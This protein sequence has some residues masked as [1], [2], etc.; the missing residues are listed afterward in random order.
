MHAIC[1][2]ADQ[3]R[4]WEVSG[5]LKVNGC[6]YIDTLNNVHT[7]KGVVRK[8]KH[9]LLSSKLVMTS[10][11]EDTSYIMSLKPKD[12]M[13]KMKAAYGF[14]ILYKVAWRA[15]Q[16]A[17]DMIYGSDAESLFNKLSWFKDCILETNP[18][19]R[20]VLEVDES[21]GRFKRLFLAYGW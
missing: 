18:A 15:R 21:S 13:I 11:Q 16:R 12:I 9:K 19:L 5:F 7:C 10:I 2:N 1:Y 6:F 4:D 20:F 14:D 3:Q 8:G 17:K